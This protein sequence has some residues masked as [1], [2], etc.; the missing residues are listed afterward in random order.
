M[1][2]RKSPRMD[3]ILKVR[4]RSK[5]DFQ[6]A[7][8]RS[9]SGVG[10]FLATKAP[11]DVGYQFLLEIHLPRKKG[12]IRGKCQVVW[13]NQIEA[14]DYPKGMGV[15]FLDLAASDRARLEGYLD[16]LRSQGG[17]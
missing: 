16:E 11:F 4:Y 6:E 1:E 13:V 15:K 2:R 14:E 17:A 12:V 9:I 7:L 8:I 10:V 5:E 3:V